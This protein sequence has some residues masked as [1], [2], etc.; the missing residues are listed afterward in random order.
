MHAGLDAELLESGR[1]AVRERVELRIV[2]TLVHE[3]ERWFRAKPFG[4]RLEHVLHGGEFERRIPAHVRRI[5]LHP[6]S[7]R[8]R[9]SSRFLMGSLI[10]RVAGDGLSFSSRVLARPSS[11]GHGNERCAPRLTGA[12]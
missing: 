9:Q 1:R 6:R 2:Y 8:H 3:I 4:G 7:D 12:V 5:G 10:R 11:V